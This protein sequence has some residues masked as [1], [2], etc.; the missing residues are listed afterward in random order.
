MTVKDQ[1]DMAERNIASL[2]IH[3]VHL[4]NHS[5][6]NDLRIDGVIESSG[7][8]WDLTEKKCQKRFSKL[9]LHNL[10]TEHAHW[11]GPKRD[12]QPRITV[13]KMASYKV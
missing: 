3:I 11:T 6:Q 1:L 8:T 2:E 5:P 4:D 7:E 13:V 9:D 12:G 10:Q